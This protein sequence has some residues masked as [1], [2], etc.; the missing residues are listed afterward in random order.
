MQDRQIVE[1]YWAREEE[2]IKET[3]AK[4]GAYL[5]KIAYNILAD[6]E[7]SK[8]CVNDTYLA[9]WNSMPTHRPNVLSAYLGK[10][11]RQ[12]TIDVF[13]KKN[14]AKRYASTYA[15]SL[16]ELTD[17]FSSEDIPEQSCEKKQLETAIN[18]FLRA[19]PEDARNTFIGRY[20]FFDPLKQ[21]AA[22]CGMSEAKAKSLLYRTRQKLKDYLTK[23][24]FM[25]EC[26]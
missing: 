5:S 25:D 3:Q 11:T 10:I 8:E 18:Q 17:T 26:G 23:E 13:R 2:A 21:V 24:G 16:S 14:S 15:L 20:Y 4:Y 6:F 1:L 7:D 19:L 9:A 12:I 22:Y